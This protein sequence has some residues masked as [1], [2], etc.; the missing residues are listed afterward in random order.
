MT[1]YAALLL[2]ETLSDEEDT[3]D[4]MEVIRANKPLVLLTTDKTMNSSTMSASMN[5][6]N[7]SSLPFEDSFVARETSEFRHDTSL[8][9]AVAPLAEEHRATRESFDSI[10]VEF[11]TSRMKSNVAAVGHRPEESWGETNGNSRRLS[12]ASDVSDFGPMDDNIGFYQDEDVV[13]VEEFAAHDISPVV[14]RRSPET[15]TNVR[16][17]KSKIGSSEKRRVSFGDDVLGAS[18]SSSIQRSKRSA[19]SVQY[20][21]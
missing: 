12:V 13:A 21:V 9:T 20:V 4:E 16:G 11:E 1:S 6:S 7:D 5:A 17:R 2:D 3:A 8:D 10:G 14:S 18:A 19:V 15:S